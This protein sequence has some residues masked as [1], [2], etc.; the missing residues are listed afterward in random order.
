MTPLWGAVV[1]KV[2]RGRKDLFSR[3]V[4]PGILPVYDF[5]MSGRV[6]NVTGS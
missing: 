2:L 4:K 5:G 6:G 3:S 1:E